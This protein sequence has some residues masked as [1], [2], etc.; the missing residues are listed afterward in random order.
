M[1]EE[2]S[3]GL[4][5]KILDKL[6]QHDKLLEGINL[7]MIKINGKLIDHDDRFEKLETGIKD[8][9]LTHFDKIYYK[10]ESLEQE[11]KI[12]NLV[13]KNLEQRIANVDQRLGN[14]EVNMVKREEIIEIKQQ[15]ID[16]LK[17]IERLEAEV[18]I[19]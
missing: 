5:D 19:Q 4:A 16:L 9:A 6:T 11:Y 13:V 3:R 1:A 17:R 7:A 18:G 12:L 8:F 10:L 2:I 15:A 14:I